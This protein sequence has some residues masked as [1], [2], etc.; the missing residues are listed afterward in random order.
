MISF[1]DRK[2]SQK[3][4]RV[5]NERDISWIL[6]NQGIT[7]DILPDDFEKGGLLVNYPLAITSLSKQ[8]VDNT[9]VY[10]NSNNTKDTFIDMSVKGMHFDENLTSYLET[11]FLDLQCDLK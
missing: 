7:D 8:I 5:A 4:T 3:H 11:N 6:K 2:E 10:L 1:I 9:E